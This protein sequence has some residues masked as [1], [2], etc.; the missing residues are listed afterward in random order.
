[1]K[2]NVLLD[3]TPTCQ[4]G[5]IF[6]QP[7]HNSLKYV[8]CLIT[9]WG[10]TQSLK[11]FCTALHC[12]CVHAYSFS[13]VSACKRANIW[14]SHHS[15]W[16]SCGLNEKEPFGWFSFIFLSCFK[17]VLFSNLR[18]EHSICLFVFIFFFFLPFPGVFH[19]FSPFLFKGSLSVRILAELIDSQQ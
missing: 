9:E 10:I 19:P 11:H 3:C 16:K 4:T 1:M 7:H 12:C 18:M 6:L 13:T 15:L 14:G 5:K 2:T 17:A 8:K